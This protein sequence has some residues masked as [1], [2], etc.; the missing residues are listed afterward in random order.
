MYGTRVAFA[1]ARLYFCSGKLRT[2]AGTGT[3]NVDIGVYRHRWERQAPAPAQT[4][5]KVPVT[6]PARWREAGQYQ[7]ILKVPVPDIG[8]GLREVD[9]YWN[10]HRHFFEVP[11]GSVQI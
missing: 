6:A 1:N 8:R 9:R 7:H 3:K 10:W 4:L 5:L 11:A 2:K